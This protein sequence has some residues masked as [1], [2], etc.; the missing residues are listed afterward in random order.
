MMMKNKKMRKAVIICS[1]DEKTDDYDQNSAAIPALLI[2]SKMKIEMNK[3][4]F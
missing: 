3:K 1:Y 4:A 2:R